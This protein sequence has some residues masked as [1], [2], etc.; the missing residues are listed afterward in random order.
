MVC[1]A[2][3]FPP[4]HKEEMSDSLIGPG[5]EIKYSPDRTSA[6]YC[7]HSGYATNLGS[8]PT[9]YCG[10]IPVRGLKMLLL[11]SKLRTSNIVGP[12]QGLVSP[13]PT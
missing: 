9:H 3:G 2:A 13:F 5:Q 7:V 4:K 11:G 12:A 10:E 1:D 6:Q 8:W